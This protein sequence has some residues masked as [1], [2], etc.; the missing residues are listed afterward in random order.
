[1]Q[2]FAI[3]G[4]KT[5]IP[6]YENIASEKDFLSGNFDTS[7]IDTHPH[8]FLYDEDSSEVGKLARLIAEIH[9]RKENPY[10]A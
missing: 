4:P 5:T 3:R 2:N 10:A 9:Y 7:Y 8:I 1:L 6:F